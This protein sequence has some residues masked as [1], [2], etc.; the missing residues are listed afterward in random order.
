MRGRFLTFEGVDGAGKSTCLAW[1]RDWIEQRGTPVLT[2]REPGGTPLGEAVRRLLLDPDGAMHAD[3]E[4]LL[5]FAARNEHVQ[6]VILPALAAGTW[7]LCDRF[8]DATLAYQGAGRGIATDRIDA[9]ARWLPA[10]PVPDA[11][12]LVDVPLDVA[13]ARIGGRGDRDR[14]EAESATF[15]ARVA[16]GYRDIAARSQGRVRVIDGSGSRDEVRA[17]VEQSLATL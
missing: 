8:L 16:Q 17:R 2:T 9:L 13:A 4:L 5:V 7:V 11:T 12:F 6:R 1:A 10:L 14:F 3:T 15:H